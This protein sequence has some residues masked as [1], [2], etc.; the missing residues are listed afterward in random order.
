MKAPFMIYKRWC[1]YCNKLF[2][3]EG[4][5]AKVCPQCREKR[6]QAGKRSFKKTIK[7]NPRVPLRT[8]LR[9]AQ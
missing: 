7:S 1:R 4:A 2:S 6:F 5:Y 8:L 3:T 9:R